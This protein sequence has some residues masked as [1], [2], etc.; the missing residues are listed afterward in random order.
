MKRILVNATQPEELRLAIVDGQR[1]LDLDLESPGR[2]QRKS[3]IYKARITRVEPSL[4]AAF[5]EYGADRHGFLPMKEISPEYFLKDASDGKLNIKELIKEGQEL[6]VQ[7]DKEERGSKGAALTTFI[8]LAGRYLVL[9]PNNPRAGGVSRRIEGEDRSELRESLADLKLPDGMGVIARTAGVGRSTEEL[10][11]DVDYLV[12][13]WDAMGKVTTERKAPFLVYQ[14]SNIIIRALRDYL[15]PDIGE[16]VVDNAEIHQQA[17]EFMQAVMP[18]LQQKLKLYS[19]SVPLFTRFQIE[20]QIETAHQRE[21][22]LPSG[23]A[24]VID[25]TEA[26]TSIDINSAK[27]TR[28]GNIEETAFNTNLEAADEIA[29]QLRLRDL[30]GLVVIDFIDMNASKNQREVENRLRDASKMDRARVQMGRISRF[31]LL[32]MSRQRLRPSLKEH[33][34]LTCPRCEGHGTIRTVESLALQILRLIE[35]EALKERTARV[36]AQL[37]VSVAI[38]LLNEKR[39]ILSELEETTRVKLS[40]VANPNLE[41]PHYDI[42]RIR[43]DQVDDDSLKLAT[44]ELLEKAQIQDEKGAAPAPRPREVQQ[45]AVGNFLPA[46]PAPE[47]TPKPA[48]ERSQ[49]SAESNGPGLISRLIRAIVA[50]F[51]GGDEAP[52]KAKA[53]T[54]GKGNRARGNA[55]QSRGAKRDTNSR[56]GSGGNRRGESSRSSRNNEITTNRDPAP[57]AASKAD[58][59]AKPQK[60]AAAAGNGSGSGQATGQGNGPANESATDEDGKPRSSRRRGRRGGRRRRGGGAGGEGNEASGNDLRSA[61]EGDNPTVDTPATKPETSAPRAAATPKPASADAGSTPVAASEPMPAAQP[62]AAS[63]EPAPKAVVSSVDPSAVTQ[64]KLPTSDAITANPAPQ[65]KAAPVEAASAAAASETTDA[66]PAKKPARRARPTPL[67]PEPTAPAAAVAPP[68]PQQPTPE[69]SKAPAAPE[70]PAPSAPS[71]AA[72]PASEPMKMVETKRTEAP[73]TDKSES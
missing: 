19:D 13:L 42:Q 72:I 11:W 57:A 52:K 47:P 43:G 36:I 20:S 68:A 73:A 59:A 17:L 54:R 30:G 6:V 34:H 18:Q 27:S 16:I 22:R 71:A 9:M 41:T 55:A 64:P 67:N 33:S 69:A 60:A 37:P 39:N 46:R 50:L 40:L 62:T 4:E 14:E 1:L 66:A 8:S 26:L 35:E 48:T 56:R 58:A 28:G 45:A 70:P 5:V 31:G 12:E 32:E 3:N 2:E 23:G 65:Q 25:A 61:A 38:Y 53:D 29:R 21:V 51:S 49:K 63:P 24:L 10:Q 15:R 44:H 7:V